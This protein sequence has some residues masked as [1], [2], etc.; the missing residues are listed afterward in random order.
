M[1]INS[2]NVYGI[3]KPIMELIE[4]HFKDA[5]LKHHSSSLIVNWTTEHKNNEEKKLVLNFQNKNFQIMM[6]QGLHIGMVI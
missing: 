6:F 1:P 4:T 2:Y 5:T 3:S